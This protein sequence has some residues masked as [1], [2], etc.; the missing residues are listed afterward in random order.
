M[1]TKKIVTIERDILVEGLNEKALQ[2]VIGISNDSGFDED[3]TSFLATSGWNAYDHSAI[4][5]AISD[6]KKRE[7]EFYK[8]QAV[9]LMQ[10]IEDFDVFI[11]KRAHGFLRYFTGL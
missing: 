11:D 2:I 7:I 9:M 4:N 3:L 10:F 5:Y 1:K 6:L 8:G